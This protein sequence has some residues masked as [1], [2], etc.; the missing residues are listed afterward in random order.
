MTS[1]YAIR[2][3]LGFSLIE[4][5]VGLVIIS[6]GLLGIAKLQALS[7]SNT[8]AARMRSLASIE[9]ASLASAM[10][11]NRAYWAANYPTITVAGTTIT[12]SDGSLTTAVNCNASGGSAPCNATLLAASDLNE[13]VTNFAALFPNGTAAITCTSATTPLS[14]TIQIGW[15]ENTVS[16]TQQAGPTAAAL[17]TQ[18]Y[19]LYVQP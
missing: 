15:T 3:S 7:L 5:M 18:T 12:S 10:H 17:Q 4:V 11:A 9:A 13:W 2:R 8:N 16:Q 1:G 6:V 14:C 19:L